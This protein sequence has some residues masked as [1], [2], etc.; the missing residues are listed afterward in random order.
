MLSHC[1]LAYIVSSVK[2]VV[3]LEKPLYLMNCFSLA[4]FGVLPLSSDNL[5]IMCLGVESSS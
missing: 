5:I 4:A 2:S 3:N 1:L